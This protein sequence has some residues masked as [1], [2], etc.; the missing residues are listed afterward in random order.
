MCVI[1]IS[2]LG[3]MAWNS[4]SIARHFNAVMESIGRA[5]RPKS[6]SLWVYTHWRVFMQDDS[7][8]YRRVE[9]F[10]T[11]TDG[12]HN[13][14][15]ITFMQPMLCVGG[16]W[17]DLPVD[18]HGQ[19]FAGEFQQF[20]QILGIAVVGDVAVFTVKLDLHRRRD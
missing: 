1:F 5:V 19:T 3:K 15:S 9:R 17:H 16:T 4:H 11:T 6:Q 14:N 2:W 13:F 18:F 20:D 12:M 7:S 8:G 10:L